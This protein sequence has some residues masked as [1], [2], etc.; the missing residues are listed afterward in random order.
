MQHPLILGDTS[1]AA[2][3]SIARHNSGGAATTVTERWSYGRERPE[4]SELRVCELSDLRFGAGCFRLP[5]RGSARPWLRSEKR[6]DGSKF[7]VSVVRK[8]AYSDGFAGGNFSPTC[9]PGLVR[10]QCL[11]R[12]VRV[13]LENGARAHILDRIRNRLVDS[14]FVFEHK[15]DRG[16]LVVVESVHYKRELTFLDHPQTRISRLFYVRED[17]FHVVIALRETPRRCLLTV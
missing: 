6:M 13:G 15:F 17:I 11:Q 8:L 5:T 4:C 2:A 9:A 10:E 1:V 7:P 3:N 12:L 14:I 16:D